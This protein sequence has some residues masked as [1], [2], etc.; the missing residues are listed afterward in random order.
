ML[1]NIP[2]YNTLGYEMPKKRPEL[3]LPNLGLPRS[4]T[5]AEHLQAWSDECDQIIG[6]MESLE[7][8]SKEW[9]LWYDQMFLQKQPPGISDAGILSPKKK[10]NSST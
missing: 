3:K 9:D 4:T 7:E 10:L 5:T 1:R 6:S 8:Q 2:L